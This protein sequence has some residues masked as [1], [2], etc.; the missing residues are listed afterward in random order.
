MMGQPNKERSRESSRFI[1]T[2]W[3]QVLAACGESQEAKQSLRELCDHYYEP[4][5]AFIRSYTRKEQEARDWTH[6]F[7]VGLMQGN[8]FENLSVE[9]G[10]FRSYLLGAVKHFLSNERSRQQAEKRGGGVGHVSIT[11]TEPHSP[12]LMGEAFPSDA[13]FDRQWAISL[14]TQGLS[15]LEQEVSHGEV[16]AR[17]FQ[18]LRPWLSGELIETDQ[19]QLA[20]QFGVSKQAIKSTLH[21]WRVRF[22]EIVRGRIAHTVDSQAAVNEELDYLLQSLSFRSER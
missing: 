14:L 6:S 10:R 21:R 20:E 15:Q 13:Y 12:L 2:H 17:M 18:A 22:R 8:G 4:V 5:F 11:E 19:Q 3:T 9:R 1:T 7:F 16:Q